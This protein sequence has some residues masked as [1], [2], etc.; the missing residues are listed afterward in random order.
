MELAPL[1]LEDAPA[2]AELLA[3]AF[4][5]S[6][7]DM[8]QLLGWLH[9]GRE[10]VAWGAWDADRLV[11]QYACLLTHL[12][13]P[14]SQTIVEAGMSLNMAV[15][16]DYRGRGLIKQVSKPVYEA[17][18]ARG[19]LAG[20]GFSNANGVKVDRHSQSYGY[21]VC[22]QLQPALAWIPPRRSRATLELTDTLPPSFHCP[23]ATL[24]GLA[25]FVNTDQF[26]YHR[27]AQ[28]PFRRYCFGLWREGENING[29]IVYRP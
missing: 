6:P 29:L 19:G 15:H 9:Q 21:Q 5:R 20:V 18:Q 8:R 25:S 17:V 7:A 4:D 2:W 13:L 16:P 23:T 24:N 14:H 12:Y 3:T 28:H 1:T 27:Y 11:A 10:L 26:I 22:G